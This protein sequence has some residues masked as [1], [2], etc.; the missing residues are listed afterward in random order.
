MNH[1][2]V[3]V[4][5]VLLLTSCMRAW[6]IFA[7]NPLRSET[8]TDFVSAL[9]VIQ[10]SLTNA[11]TT[12]QVNVTVMIY[13]VAHLLGWQL[14]IESRAA[15][16]LTATIIPAENIFQGFE[17]VG[18]LAADTG[19]GIVLGT[20]IV[21]HV[22]GANGSG[23]LAQIAFQV[24]WLPATFKIDTDPKKSFLIDD[25]LNDIPFQTGGE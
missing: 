10:L 19:N 8:V 9:P 15:P 12:G 2:I 11:T 24:S 4:L 18:L 7:D 13:N 21:G 6:T 17:T 1:K 5:T 23:V 22:T 16:N 20:C 25:E 14:L 3:V